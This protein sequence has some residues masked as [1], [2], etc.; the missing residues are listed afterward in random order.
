MNIHSLNEY[1]RAQCSVKVC[2]VYIRSG[3]RESVPSVDDITMKVPVLLLC[4]L[5]GA[6]VAKQP[7]P[8]KARLDDKLIQLLRK[9]L[10]RVRLD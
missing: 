3:N 1:A 10:A 6:A 2:S 4:L 8:G 5:L 9:A 7:G